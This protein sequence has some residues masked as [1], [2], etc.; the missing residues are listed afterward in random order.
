MMRL[1]L[2]LISF[3]ALNFQ[4]SHGQVIDPNFLKGQTGIQMPTEAE[5]LDWINHIS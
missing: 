3:V 5:V 1:F 4:N 2:L